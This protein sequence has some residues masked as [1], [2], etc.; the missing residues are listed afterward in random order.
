MSKRCS[1]CSHPEASQINAALGT[2]AMKRIADQYQLS[3]SALSR[4][5]MNHV[6]KTPPIPRYLHRHVGG[7]LKRIRRLIDEALAAIG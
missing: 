7:R 2:W 5:Y 1:I 3:R 4:H 6:L